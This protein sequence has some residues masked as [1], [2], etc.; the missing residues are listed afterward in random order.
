MLAISISKAS[1]LGRAVEIDVTEA[2]ITRSKGYLELRAFYQ[3]LAN[4]H[5]P[6]FRA[7]PAGGSRKQKA[8]IA[9]LERQMIGI[10][11]VMALAKATG[12]PLQLGDLE[13]STF[14]ADG[15]PLPAPPKMEPATDE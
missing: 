15:A 10:R 2:T 11:Q 13:I 9:D 4:Q 1:A 8:M 3:R 5:A 14:T 6:G 7:R 12:E